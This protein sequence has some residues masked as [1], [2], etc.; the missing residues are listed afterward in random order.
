MRIEIGNYGRLREVGFTATARILWFM[1]HPD[2]HTA[3]PIRDPAPSP[4]RHQPNVLMS[5]V[6]LACAAAEDIFNAVAWA[7]RARDGVLTLDDYAM[8]GTSISHP[9]VRLDRGYAHYERYP[10]FSG[11]HWVGQEVPAVPRRIFRTTAVH[12]LKSPAVLHG[13]YS[14]STQNLVVLLPQRDAT[15]LAP[16]SLVLGHPNAEWAIQQFRIG[17]DPTGKVEVTEG[18]SFIPVGTGTGHG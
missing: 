2:M 12:A 8:G 4:K 11:I 5:R 16:D 9:V 14:A 1:V 17:I 6:D 7:L 3:E 10:A 13:I 18:P 15:A